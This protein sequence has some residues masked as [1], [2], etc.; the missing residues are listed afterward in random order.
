M[1]RYKAHQ[2]R[3]AKMKLD[4]CRAFPRSIRIFDRPV[5]LF[6]RS[7]RYIKVGVA[8]MCDNWAVLTCTTGENT[9]PV[10]LEIETKTGNAVLSGKQKEWAE[11][12]RTVGVWHF[13]QR[14]DTNL[15]KKVLERMKKEALRLSSYDF[16]PSES[17]LRDN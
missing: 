2:K 17:S 11:W 9:I 6:Q 10:H 8:G 3:I 14:D 7:G 5:G 1:N 4:L 16:L 15:Q 13:I 12:C